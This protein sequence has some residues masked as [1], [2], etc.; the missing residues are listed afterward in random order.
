MLALK[1]HLAN[2]A[3][4]SPLSKLMLDL[5]PAFTYILSL[6]VHCQM[7]PS[8]FTYYPFLIEGVLATLSVI[9]NIIN[10]GSRY[11]D[12]VN[13]ETVIKTSM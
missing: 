10:S 4:D 12:K 5:L 6:T 11:I 7:L 8:A 3:V 1:H 13:I 2:L 9:N